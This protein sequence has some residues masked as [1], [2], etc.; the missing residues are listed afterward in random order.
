MRNEVSLEHIREEHEARIRD[1]EHYEQ[2]REF[3]EQQYFSAVE[4]HIS[5]RLYDSELDR[6]HMN[7]CEGTGLWLQK[8][9]T[10][11]KWLDFSDISTNLVWLQ[12]IPGSGI[13]GPDHE[14]V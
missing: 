5:P 13:L 2:T 8:D 1:F 7:I 3:Q 4:T 9:K 14:R 11:C 12:G 10:F 6:L